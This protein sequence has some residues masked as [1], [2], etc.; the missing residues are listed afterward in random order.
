M[1]KKDEL[2]L[3]YSVDCVYMVGRLV[4]NRPPSLAGSLRLNICDIRVKYKQLNLLDDI[5]D[6]NT[7][8]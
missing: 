2:N 3:W 6:R 8:S 4:F 1:C 5:N 7:S